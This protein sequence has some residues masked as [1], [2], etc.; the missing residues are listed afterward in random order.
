MTLTLQDLRG[1]RKQRNRERTMRIIFQVAAAVSILISLLILVALVRGSFDFL[2]K[3][4][5]DFG[6]FSDTGW[7]PRRERFDLRTIFVGSVIMGAVAM[8]VAVPLGLG[9]AI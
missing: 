4:G 3:V 6:L 9:T 2:R 8:L 1:S 7:F 5:W